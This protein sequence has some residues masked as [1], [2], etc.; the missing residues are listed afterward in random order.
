MDGEGPVDDAAGNVPA[1]GPVEPDTYRRVKT[2]LIERIQEAGPLDG[3]VHDIHGAM[4]VDGMEDADGDLTGA[5]RE[6]IGQ[7]AL[8]SAAMDP[9]GNVSERFVR[10]LD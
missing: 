6:A 4:S 2:E 1:G 3:L 10:D 9:H 8:I 5:A 7:H